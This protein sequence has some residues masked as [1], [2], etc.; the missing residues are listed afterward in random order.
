[1]R[2]DVLIAL[3]SNLG[4][5][6]QH[7]GHA[8]AALRR[9]AWPDALFRASRIYETEPI[10][11]AQPSYLNV[12]VRFT[13]QL[14][15]AYVMH[16]LLAIEKERGRERNERWGPRTLDLDIIRVRYAD[17]GAF[18]TCATPTL[19]LPHPEFSRRAFVLTPMRDVDGDRDLATLLAN[20]PSPHGVHIFTP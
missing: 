6:L 17:T 20:I 4:D 14:H 18:F 12:C 15:P 8:T 3:G 2:Y 19:T 1:M 16:N 5:R 13:T 9:L 10:G 11:P 7:L